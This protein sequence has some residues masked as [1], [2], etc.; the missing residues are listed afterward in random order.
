M[1]WV[2]SNV[3]LL[4]L[5]DV[6]RIRVCSTRRARFK[7]PSSESESVTGRDHDDASAG[8]AGPATP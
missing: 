8:V 7:F 4:Q 5:K 2:G 3:G 1:L 6:L